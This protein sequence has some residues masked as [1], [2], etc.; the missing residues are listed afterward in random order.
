MY[1]HFF[2]YLIITQA[3][4]LIVNIKKKSYWQFKSDKYLYI[5]KSKKSKR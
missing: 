5:H 3:C 4:C 1:I 2:I